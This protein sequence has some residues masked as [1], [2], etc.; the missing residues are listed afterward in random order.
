MIFFYILSYLN[1]LDRKN[2]QNLGLNLRKIS[3]KSLF[4]VVVVV[5]DD[6]F[7]FLFLI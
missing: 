6:C 7:V 4:F 3:R 2:L 1:N 5:V